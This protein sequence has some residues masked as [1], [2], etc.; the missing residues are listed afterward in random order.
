M[1]NNQELHLLVIISF[2]LATLIC[3]SGKILQGEITY[4]SLLG[5]QGI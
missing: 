3:D 1:F 5:V 2:I 4:Q